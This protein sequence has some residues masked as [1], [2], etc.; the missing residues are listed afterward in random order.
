MYARTRARNKTPYICLTKRAHDE[1]GFTQP[2]KLSFAV[3]RAYISPTTPNAPTI[4]A[5]TKAYKK[6]ISHN[7]EPYTRPLY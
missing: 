3:F 1:C 4:L 5:N 6:A 7:L 2:S